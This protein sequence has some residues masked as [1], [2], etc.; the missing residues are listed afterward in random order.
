[1]KL[2]KKIYSIKYEKI[3]LILLAPLSII[4]FLKANNDFK[5]NSI[6][7][8]LILYG[9]LALSVRVIRKEALEEIKKG[10]YEPILDLEDILENVKVFIN[11]INSLK[12]NIKKEVIKCK[13][14]IN[15]QAYILR[16]ANN[17]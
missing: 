5:I 2:Y 6:L 8:S 10:I 7:M 16:R 9:G 3:L 14:Y 13:K 11:N 12:E 1:M 17:K 15:D 4:Q